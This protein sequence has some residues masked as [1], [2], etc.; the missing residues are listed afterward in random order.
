MSKFSVKKPYTIVVAVIGILVLGIV[1]FTRMTTDLLPELTLPYLVVMTTY[2]G[3]SPEKVE[4]NVTKPQEAGLATINQVERIQSISSENY[5][6]VI[7]EFS[8]GVDMGRAM[9]ETREELDVLSGS[10]EEGIGKPVMMQISP[11]MLPIMV[12]AV[13]ADGYD[14]EALSVLMKEEIAP[15]LEGVDGVASVSANGLIERTENI[16]ISQEKIAKVNAKLRE[17]IE[18]QLSEAE[19]QLLEAKA[20]LE[21]GKAELEGQMA[22]LQEGSIQADQGFL[23]G[24]ME[25]V[26]MELAMSQSQADLQQQKAILTQLNNALPQLETL[27]AGLD[28]QNGQVRE[29]IAASQQ[30]LAQLQS[31]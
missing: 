27:L 21:A 28:A 18:A 19:A 13:D 30:E 25:L 20:Q 29:Q 12:A 11:D 10:M 9:L 16:V 3:A 24:R 4:Q 7:L 1:A 15:Y 2:P 6:V 23:Q 17:K 31:A 22:A 26:K 8:D 14:T 5:A